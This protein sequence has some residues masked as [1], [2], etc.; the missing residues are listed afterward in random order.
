[1]PTRTFKERAYQA[2]LNGGRLERI[3]SKDLPASSVTVGQMN[4]LLQYA[5]NPS[6]GSYAGVAKTATAVTGGDTPSMTTGIITLQAPLSNEQALLTFMDALSVVST[7]AGTLIVG[8]L[9]AYYPSLDSNTSGAQAMLGTPTLGDAIY[10]RAYQD[11]EGVMIFA[12]VQVALGAGAANLTVT[13]TDQ[14][15][16]SG[17]TVSTAMLVSSPQGKLPYVY[18]GNSPFLRL[19]AGDRGVKSIQSFNLSAGMGAGGT[20]ALC[21]FKPLLTIPV[22]QNTSATH[23]YGMWEGLSNLDAILLETNPALSMIW[24]PSATAVGT[25]T[26]MAK[27]LNV[28]SI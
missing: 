13:Y 21:L 17:T 4:S 3:W 18:T 22:V 6:A 24:V 12:D 11:Y 25:L 1:M 2:L 15:N 5:G 19:A 8:D 20:F 27:A 10:T 7:Q 26:G 23:N 28:R 16:L 14:D 9:L